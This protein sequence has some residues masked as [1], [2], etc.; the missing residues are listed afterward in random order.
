MKGLPQNEE[1]VEL[2]YMRFSKLGH[3]HH[4]IVDSLHLLY[5]VLAWSVRRFGEEGH[6]YIFQ[7]VS[8]SELLA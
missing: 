7:S 3:N 2:R 1:L 4:Y 8:Y 5:N 6:N